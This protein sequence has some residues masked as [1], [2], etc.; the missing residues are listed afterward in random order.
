MPEEKVSLEEAIRAYTLGS[1]FAEFEERRNG[2]LSPGKFADPIV[3]SQDIT[4]VSPPEFLPTAVLLT[5]VGGKS[6]YQKE[7]AH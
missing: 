2:T 5:R 7:Q 6:V 1:A 3:L 4:N